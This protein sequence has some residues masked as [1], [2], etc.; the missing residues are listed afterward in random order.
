MP[1]IN[2][3]VALE[4]EHTKLKLV[5]SSICEGKIRTACEV[6]PFTEWSGAA[7]YTYI[8]KDGK[9]GTTF[10]EDAILKIVDF[11]LQDIGSAGYTEY[12][13]DGDTASYYAEHI[14]ELVGCKVCLLHSHHNMGKLFA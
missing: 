7:F 14:D 5:L 4:Q 1:Q 10:M 11:T 6:F 13:L 8:Y 3:T 12:N 9:H 2:T